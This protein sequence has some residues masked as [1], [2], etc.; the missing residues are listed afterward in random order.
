M[1][2]DTGP[3]GEDASKPKRA[4][5]LATSVFFLGIGALGPFNVYLLATGQTD[6]AQFDGWKALLLPFGAWML[7]GSLLMGLTVAWVGGI[8]KYPNWGERAAAVLEWW[9]ALGWWLLGIGI[10]VVVAAYVF[11]GLAAYLSRFDR[12]TLL[13]AG[14]LVMILLAL[15]RIGN[16]MKRR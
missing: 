16:Q 15:L 14:L 5:W 1:N 2:D 8:K 6:L 12:G 7:T 10:A 9:C 4:G 11:S 13:I 3:T